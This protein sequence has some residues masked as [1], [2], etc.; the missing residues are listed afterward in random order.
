ML[1]ILTLSLL[2]ALGLAEEGEQKVDTVIGID[3][4][5]TYSCVGV[6]KNGKVE[7]IANDQGNRVTPSYVA[8][9][10]AERLIGD[11]A[12]NQASLNP[13]NTVYDAKR[14]IGRR[15]TDAA[16]Q[17]DMKLWPFGVVPKEGK[18]MIEVEV[19]GAKKVFSPEE[20]SAM[21]LIKMKET[22]E[23]FLGKDV[24]NAVVTV[25]AYFNDAQRQATKD[26]GTI[27]GLNVMRIINEPT[28]AAIAYGLDK[29]SGEKNILVF[30]LGGG[31]FDVS[32]LTIDNGVFEVI[33]T[34]GDTHL[35]GEDFDNRIIQHMLKVFKR[36]HGSDPSK[37]KRA[38]QKLRREVERAKRSLSSQHQ[39]RVEIEGLFDGQDFSETLTR[40]RFEELC[41]DLF[42]KTLTPVSKVME[43]S[44]LKKSEIDEVVLVGGSTRI[45]KVQQLLKDFFNGKE[46]NKGINPDE[47][48]AFGA[49]VQGGILSGE[50]GEETKDLLLLDVTPL[51]LGLET[52]GEVMTVL[53]PRNT[54]VPTKKSQTFSTYSDNQPAV[55]IQVFEGERSRTKDNN[56]LGEFNLSGIPPMP[57]GVPQIDVTF[58]ID[59]NGMLNVS[60]LEKSTGKEN[61]ITITNDKSRLSKED[62]EKMTADA[63]KY[64]KEDEEFKEKVE[65]KNG[66]ENYCYSMKNTLED[67]KVKDKIS[68]E[69]KKKGLDAVEE[70]LKWLEG[71]QLAEK[72]E[73]SHKQK[74]V[75]GI[76]SPIMQ[77]MYSQG[78]GGDMGGMPGGMPGHPGG[79]KAGTLRMRG[80]P[81]RAT[82]DDVYRFFNGF[83][84]LPGGIVLGQRDGR[85]SGE[86]WVTF[87]SPAEAQRA[88]GMNHKNMG[89]RYVEL[90]AA[91]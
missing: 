56:K 69:D 43:D 25:P 90:F 35:G 41:I 67:D 75:E 46:P 70:A 45:P 17:H 83:H 4:G 1:R 53:I 65:A 15:F 48:V 23:A 87:S 64:A 57:R 32:L 27:A 18:P 28:A 20:I 14:L 6:Y 2:L 33:A 82:V 79:G 84:V 8:F 71:N 68:E 63:E 80:L 26:A 85:P 89:S 42:K 30:D 44:E 11:A 59:A 31:T 13:S 54:T 50:G 76:C 61:K 88:L 78:A 34:S 86:A 60:A 7:I 37:D 49:A 19:S 16:V 12:K 24:K 40:A 29:K 22:A 52:A 3:L 73:F 10:D 77:A 81:F 91:S 58:D 38:I 66:L 74:E 5:T 51:S 9:A 39:V 36:K 47:A 62:V 21:V 55:T 72:E